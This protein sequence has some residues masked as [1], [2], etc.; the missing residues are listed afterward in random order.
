M[1]NW[2]LYNIQDGVLY[3]ESKCYTSSRIG[4]S[5]LKSNKWSGDSISNLAD[6]QYD[7][8]QGIIKLKN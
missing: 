6:E 8:T 1:V 4:S 2:V 5:N 7:S 3:S